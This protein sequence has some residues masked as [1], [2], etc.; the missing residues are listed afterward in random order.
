MK[1]TYLIYREFDVGEQTQIIKDSLVAA[2]EE[3]GPT[4]VKIF[5][6]GTPEPD[7]EKWFYES[8]SSPAKEKEEVVLIADTTLDRSV[9]G[10]FG[11]EISPRVQT[12]PNSI[13][14]L[15]GTNNPNRVILDEILEIAE[16]VSAHGIKDFS[17]EKYPRVNPG[18]KMYSC[19]DFGDIHLE[20]VDES[21]NQQTLRIAGEMIGGL[22]K[23]TKGD[24]TQAVVCLERIMDHR[25]FSYQKLE[26]EKVLKDCFSYAGFE[27]VTL[28]KDLENIPELPL[29]ANTLIF[30]D[31][32]YLGGKGGATPEKREHIQG[33]ESVP[34]ISLPLENTRHSMVRA[35]LLDRFTFEDGESYQQV[36]NQAIE[37]CLFPIVGVER[38][39]TKLSGELEKLEAYVGNVGDVVG[40]E[41]EISSDDAVNN[42]EEMWIRTVEGAKTA[43]R[44]VGSGKLKW[45]EMEVQE[46]CDK[47]YDRLIDYYDPSK[48]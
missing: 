1:K 42:F 39:D 37:Y 29:P 11:Q 35:G 44:T 48:S 45:G 21:P 17:R 6:K 14:K 27:S 26:R 4:T 15:F 19:L 23:K 36:L 20:E 46:E 47:L 8:E 7:I 3:I 18:H 25:P 16:F 10:E 24:F 31:R 22:V 43:E 28:V 34:V 5:P 30:G 33:N 40:K 13:K 12:L 2:L 9:T 38:Y 41:T 32:H